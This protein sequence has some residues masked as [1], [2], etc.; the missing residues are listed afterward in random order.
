MGAEDYAGGVLGLC[1]AAQ[2]QEVLHCRQLSQ[3][4]S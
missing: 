3:Q 1:H 4:V 2:P